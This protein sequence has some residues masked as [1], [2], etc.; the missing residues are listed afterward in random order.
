MAN[1]GLVGSLL[2]ALDE[3]IERPNLDLIVVAATNWPQNL[4][5]NLLRR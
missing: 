3:V 2:D 4:P 1:D 5:D